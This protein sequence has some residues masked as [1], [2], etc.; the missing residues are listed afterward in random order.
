M[1]THTEREH[2]TIKPEASQ[3]TLDAAPEAGKAYPCHLKETA[4]KEEQ[5]RSEK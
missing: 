3:L 1:C 2:I 5:K 4:T